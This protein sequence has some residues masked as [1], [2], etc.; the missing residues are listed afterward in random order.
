MDCDDRFRACDADRERVAG[1]LRDAYT[2]GRLSYSE[3]EERMTAAFAARTWGDLRALTHDLPVAADLGPLRVAAPANLRRA[4][5]PQPAGMGIP[6]L[7]IALVWLVASLSLH[8]GAALIPV[9][10]FVLAGIWWAAR[11]R[12]GHR[13]RPG[14]PR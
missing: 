7:P 4:P 10:F 3:F 9:M 1:I 14:G 5:G 11:I 12:D 6:V 13:S 2:A 8:E